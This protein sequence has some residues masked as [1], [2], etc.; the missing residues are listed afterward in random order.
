[1]VYVQMHGTS[2]YVYT[3][4]SHPEGILFVRMYF[5]PPTLRKYLLPFPAVPYGAARACILS[6]YIEHARACI[7]SLD[8]TSPRAGLSAAF[9]IHSFN[10]FLYGN[11]K[12]TF[13]ILVN[14]TDS[15]EL[16]F[17]P[18]RCSPIGIE[19]YPF[20]YKNCYNVQNV[21]VHKY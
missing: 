20:K 8:F 13:E 7:L 10:I 14:K 4:H 11:I 17:Q 3:L 16:M 1:M 6:Y 21:T 2:L 5:F 12:K 18:L 19:M 15:D 9:N